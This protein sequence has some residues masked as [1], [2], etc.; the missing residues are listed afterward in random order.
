MAKRA[1]QSRSESSERPSWKGQLSFGLITLTVE[2]FNALNRQKSDIHFHQLHAKCHSR[3]HYEKVCPLHGKVSND[4]IV[5]GYE[6]REGKYVEFDPDELNALRSEREKGLRID[7]FVGPDTIDPLYFDGR[8][9]YVLP[10]GASAQEAF[11]IIVKAMAA[12]DRFG[13]GRIVMSG[14]DQIVL[15]RPIHGILHMAMLNYSAEIR[16]PKPRGAK[17]ASGS[18][19]LKIAQLLV[20]QW[21]DDDFD[22]GQ[23]KDDYRDQVEKLIKAKT[24][25]HEVQA[26][27]VEDE[28]PE[29][30]NLMEALQKSLGQS[31]GPLR[32][33]TRKKSRSR[34][35]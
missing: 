13:V 16:S 9:Y 12:E 19:Q 11:D 27:E 20:Q 10:A 2:A 3:I 23:Y 30:L 14:K 1:R 17:V 25:G 26:P 28:Q 32:R 6:V 5:S 29:T 31:R 7:A 24:K 35:A 4:E 15:L 21:S 18:K 8:M 33:P 34:T 22:F